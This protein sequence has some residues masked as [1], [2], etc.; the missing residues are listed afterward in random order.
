MLKMVFRKSRV[1]VFPAV[2]G[3]LQFPVKVSGAAARP[4]MI[5]VLLTLLKVTLFEIVMGAVAN[6]LP[7]LWVAGVAMP[8]F[9]TYLLIPPLPKAFPLLK[10]RPALAPIA[11]PPL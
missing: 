8:T 5:M 10:F 3:N 9:V 2:A 4:T 6:A 11:A 1:A 7:P